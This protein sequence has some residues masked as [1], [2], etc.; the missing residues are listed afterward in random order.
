MLITTLVENTINKP[1]LIGEHGLSFLIKTEEEEILFDTGQG[2]AILHNAKLMSVDLSRI[3]KIILSHGHYDH[4]G[5]LKTILKLMDDVHIYGHPNIFDKK[6]AKDREK[7]RYIGISYTKEELETKGVQLHLER[8]P[9]QIT[10]RIK[11]SG[12]IKRKT[13]F[14]TISDRLCVM[15]DGELVKDD[16]LDDLSL[17]ISGREGISI[18]LGCGHSGVINILEHTQMI[19]NNVPISYLIGGIHLIDTNK[20]TIHKT[21]DRLKEFNIGKMALCHCTGFYALSELQRAFGDKL[22]INNT[23]DKIDLG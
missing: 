14:E 8:E 11:T 20:N 19:T 6:Y 15:R 3:K 2:N 22:I 17:I 10:N 4:T 1:G 18:I 12:E 16:I 5:G 21:I 13:D 23:G 9:I 7:Q